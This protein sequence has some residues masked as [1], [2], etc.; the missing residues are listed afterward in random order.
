MVMMM[1][2]GGHSSYTQICHKIMPP[3]SKAHYI[4][5]RQI[6]LGSS[7]SKKKSLTKDPLQ[8]DRSYY[9]YYELSKYLGHS[10]SYGDD[11]PGHLLLDLLLAVPAG[12]YSESCFGQF[13]WCPVM[14]IRE[15]VGP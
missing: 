11:D 10:F 7:S 8:V 13:I 15:K 1:V 14:G 9:S 2:S 6:S 3:L 12:S 4:Y 5:M